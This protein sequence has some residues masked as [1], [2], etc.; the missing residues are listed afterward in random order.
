MADD[1]FYQTV[2]ETIAEA[3]RAGATALNLSGR[4]AT[5]D[6]QKFAELP[7]MLRELKQLQELNLSNNGLEELSSSG[8][9]RLVGIG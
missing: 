8:E 9:G 3:H 5:D 4:L 2:E 1:Q 7:R 6:D